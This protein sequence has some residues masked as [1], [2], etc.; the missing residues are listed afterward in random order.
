MFGQVFLRFRQ[1]L[2]WFRWVLVR[3]GQVLV[4]IKIEPD[5]LKKSIYFSKIFIKNYFGIFSIS[6]I[7]PILVP[8]VNGLAHEI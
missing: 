4:A 8:Q 7:G 1:V 6:V 2:V 5:L 3:F